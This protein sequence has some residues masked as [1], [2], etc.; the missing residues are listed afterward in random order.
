MFPLGPHIIWQI[1]EMAVLGSQDDY[2]I[3]CDGWGTELSV[4]CWPKLSKP[5]AR[6][7]WA[8][9]FVTVQY[10]QNPIGEATE[11]DAVGP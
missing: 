6:L 11:A 10:R 2:S 7:G 4:D 9:G 1:A 8:M 5:S 3:P